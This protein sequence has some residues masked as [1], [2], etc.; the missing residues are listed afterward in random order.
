MASSPSKT[1]KPIKRTSPL[2][3][4]PAGQQ[5]PSRTLKTLG[6]IPQLLPT[7]MNAEASSTHY[8]QAF[9]EPE[10]HTPQAR[11]SN[12][13]R[14]PTKLFEQ[15]P[16][17]RGRSPAKSFSDVPFEVPYTES[18]SEPSPDRETSPSKKITRQDMA[19]LNPPV[20]FKTYEQQA[21]STDGIPEVVVFLNT[22]VEDSLGGRGIVPIG[23]KVKF[24]AWE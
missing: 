13:S 24:S 17:R 9:D 3:K 7:S 11:R 1:P 12:R 19:T 14:S 23:L 15:S 16:T 21:V 6:K 2:R 22:C 10:E 5:T 20:E 4:E 18:A 8:G